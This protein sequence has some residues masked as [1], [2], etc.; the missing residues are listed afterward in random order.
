MKP[1]KSRASFDVAFT[2][3]ELLV[4]IAIIAILAAMLLP[5]LSKAKDRAMEAID[6]NNNKQILTAML[7]FTTDN[8]EQMPDS[9]WGLV[10]CWAYGAPVPGGAGGS[11]AA[12]NADLP[13]QLNALKAGQLFPI[14]AAYKLYMCPADKVGFGTFYQR[15]IQFC[16]Y[17][18]N[19]A[20]NEYMGGIRPHKITEFKPLD[21][22]QW[23]TDEADPFL[24]NDCVN[25]PTEGLSSRHRKGASVGLFG[26]STEKMRAR[27]EFLNLAS[28][29]TKNRLWCNP[30]TASGH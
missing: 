16:S 26:G 17:S 5:T 25:F 11:D 13:G 22:L 18:W 23:E 30:A 2:L 19:G 3:I 29:A 24:F 1:S 10:T 7:M 6:L 14:A 8:R 4:V 20:V 12:Y 27:T 21:I 15:K 28:S 9:G